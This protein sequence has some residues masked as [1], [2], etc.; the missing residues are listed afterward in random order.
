[1]QDTPQLDGRRRRDIREQLESLT[2]T[3]TDEW[4]PGNDDAGAAV[5]DLFAA[6]AGDLIERL[7]QAP[8]R[9]RIEFFDTLGFARRPPQAASTPVT[10]AVAEDAPENVTIP[11]GTELEAEADGEELRY[12]V[13]ADDAFEATPARLAAVYCVDPERDRITVHHDVI[14]GDGTSRL[15]A[16]EN[17]QQHA[18]YIGHPERLDIGGESNISLKIESEGAS[19]LADLEWEFFGEDADA[20]EGWHE[21]SRQDD[22]LFS[23]VIEPGEQILETERGGIESCWIRC[24]VPQEANVD[25]V[26]I[27]DIRFGR[28]RNLAPIDGLYAN[29]V[30]QPIGPE[31]TTG[32]ESGTIFPFG[33]TPRQ[34]PTFYIACEEAFTKAGAE[35]TLDF[36]VEDGDARDE[37]EVGEVRISWEY[38]DGNAWQHL[39]S[40]IHD[41]TDEIPCKVS[42]TAPESIAQGSVAGQEGVWIRA[43]LVSGEFLAVGYDDDDDPKRTIEGTP[44]SLQSVEIRYE[45]VEPDPMPAQLVAENNLEFGDNLV[46]SFPLEPFEPIPDGEQAVYLGFDGPLTGGPIQ[47]YVDP[48]D[49]RYPTTFAP[50][51]S[52]EYAPEASPTDWQRVPGSDGSDGF[53]ESGIVALTFSEATRPR[54]R[55]DEKRHWIRSRVR[56]NPFEDDSGDRSS[57]STSTTSGS[58]HEPCR[59]ALRTPGASGEV[60]RAPPAVHGIY[61]NAG[62]VGN[63]TIVD[64]EVLGSSDGT[65]NATYAVTDPPIVDAEVWVDERTALSADARDRFATKWPD[66]IEIEPVAGTGDDRVWVRWKPV[67]DFLSSGE[68]DRHYVVDRVAGEIVFGNDTAGRIPPHGEDNIRVSYRTGGGGAGNVPPGAVDDLVS[69]IPLVEDVENPVAAGG[70]ADAESTA[71]V[72]ERA[73]RE[74]RDRGR[75]VTAADFER[76]AMDAS[77]RLAAVRCIPGLNAAGEHDPGHVTVV[78]VP[79]DGRDVPVPS[80]ELTRQ[81][82]D[83]LRDRAPLP[84]V[85]EEDRLV[86]R[87]PSYVRVRAEATVVAVDGATLGAVE[88][89]IVGHLDEF[90][91]PLVGPEGDGWRFGDLPSVSD[92]F[93]LIEGREGVDH[94]DSLRIH[95]VMGDEDLSLV[96]G[97]D[98]PDTAPDVLVHSGVHDLTIEPYR[99]PCQEG[100]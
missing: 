25:D 76:I 39:P 27:D 23:F 74:L 93:A 30:P 19:Q 32:P 21:L 71:A 40:E 31:G 55:F 89:A 80:A 65:P 85:A 64:D 6:M 14:D 37:E 43:R 99:D 78:I 17:L 62:R 97:D 84:L 70:G 47:L 12:R 58:G 11:P 68:D 54:R 26:E 87:E 96:Q 95:Y 44:P 63:V 100:Q 69:G 77:R 8:E 22:D 18:L 81:V 28:E 41:W 79:N 35:V 34:R 36:D 90:L 86:V 92:L 20:E 98:L 91:H 60:T 24:R 45:Y 66:R 94:V 2:P 59:P 46:E 13:A 88:D 1:M 83:T 72:L 67:A 73:P 3:Y 51:I 15:F 50:R 29:D 82:E 53:T 16:G 52:W 61:A 42:F 10:F 49:R 38:F 48:E 56:G 33:T 75:A 57:E 7:D 5:V 9:H 4:D